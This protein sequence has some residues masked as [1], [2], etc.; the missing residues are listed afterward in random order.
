[1]STSSYDPAGTMRML[2]KG[3]WIFLLTGVLWLVM[4]PIVF[5]MELGTVYAIS[6]L[7]GIVAIAAGIDEFL[8]LGI[9][10]GGWK[11][12][13]GLLGAIFVIAGIVAFANPDWTFLALASIIGWWFLFKGTFDVIA[14]L[15]LKRES[16]VWWLQLVVGLIELGLAFWVAGDFNEKVI[17]LV[18]YV[19]VMCL[20][21]GITNI[22]LSFR[23][24]GVKK[25]LA[26]A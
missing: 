26:A 9:V 8:S 19:G 17:L 20:S 24:R 13:H 5:R 3:W 11:W 14:A 2:S 16:D 18:V 6:I 1:V 25:E 4:S 21:K 23:L 15:A 22:I 12:L 10:H 7:F